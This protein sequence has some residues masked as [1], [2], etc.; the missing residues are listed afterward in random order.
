VWDRA[1][2]TPPSHALWSHLHWVLIPTIALAA[3]SFHSVERPAMDWL[4]ERTSTARLRAD[5]TQR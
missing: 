4:R 5:T 2:Q 1:A 3:A